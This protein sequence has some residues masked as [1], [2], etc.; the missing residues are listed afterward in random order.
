MRN[1]P[2]R[3][4]AD[5]HLDPKPIYNESDCDERAEARTHHRS[6]DVATSHYERAKRPLSEPDPKLMDSLLIPYQ[7]IP[8]QSRDAA[9]VRTAALR[10][11]PPLPANGCTRARFLDN[12]LISRNSRAARSAS[13]SNKGRSCRHCSD[14]RKSQA[15]RNSASRHRTRNN[16]GLD[17]YTKGAGCGAPYG[18]LKLS[19]RKLK[20][21]TPWLMIAR[22]E[23]VA[24]PAWRRPDYEPSQPARRPA[25][26]IVPAPRRAS[27]SIGRAQQ[28]VG[29]NRGATSPEVARATPQGVASPR[30]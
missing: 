25:V 24:T 20:A 27:G 23:A 21:V 18:K 1:R 17:R 28:R 12:S 11:E 3:C 22:Q 16:L 19:G 2:E 4:G 8:Y 9:C 29:A 7:F 26:S 30:W 13:A 6:I 10:Q 14:H 5:R 15:G